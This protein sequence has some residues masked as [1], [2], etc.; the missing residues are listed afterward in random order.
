MKKSRF[1]WLALFA[2]I[3]VLI[4]SGCGLTTSTATSTGNNPTTLIIIL[5]L[6]F[7]VF[8]FLTIRPQRKR[9]KEQ[10]KLIEE[11]KKG[12]R[13]ITIGGLYGVIEST[14]GE[15]IVISLESGATVRIVKSAVHHKINTD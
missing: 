3:G 14:D 7:A 10:Q 5:V 1:L 8:Y 2:L 4:L 13:I 6:I 9:Q 15:S 12:D 11:L